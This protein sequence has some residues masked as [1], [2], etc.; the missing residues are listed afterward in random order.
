M[1]FAAVGLKITDLVARSCSGRTTSLPCG[2]THSLSVGLT[3][4]NGV[5]FSVAHSA[6]FDWPVSSID[7]RTPPSSLDPFNLIAGVVC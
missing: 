1:E 6:N 5:F 2:N 7:I 3:L 4:M